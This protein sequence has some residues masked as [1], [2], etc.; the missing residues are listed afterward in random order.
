MLSFHKI[1]SAILYISAAQKV[2]IMLDR[3]KS[4]WKIPLN[5]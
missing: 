5:L 4:T 3:E 2:W 1:S